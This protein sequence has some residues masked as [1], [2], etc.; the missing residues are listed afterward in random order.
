[1]FVDEIENKQKIMKEKIEANAKR[2]QKYRKFVVPIII[3]FVVYKKF[4]A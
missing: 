3:M 4:I 2:M 1:M